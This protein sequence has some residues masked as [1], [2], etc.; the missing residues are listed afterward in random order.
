MVNARLTDARRPMQSRL[1]DRVHERSA[2]HFCAAGKVGLGEPQRE[3]KDPSALRESKP[4]VRAGQ[5]RDESGKL[6][7]EIAT[8]LV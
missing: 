1:H 7:A 2:A 4:S 5:I 6:V 8:L 3:G